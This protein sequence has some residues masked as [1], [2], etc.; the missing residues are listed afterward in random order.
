MLKKQFRQDYFDL[1]KRIK[2]PNHYDN[3]GVHPSK[4]GGLI[5]LRSAVLAAFAT[6]VPRGAVARVH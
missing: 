4:D 5:K 6:T 2:Y 3:D 1:G